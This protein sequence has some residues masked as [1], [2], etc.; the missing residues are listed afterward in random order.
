M[1]KEE[2][3]RRDLIRKKEWGKNN[4]EEIK[5][6]RRQYYLKNTEYCKSKSKEWREKN[7][8]YIIIKNK[9][10]NLKNKDKVKQYNREYY[11]KNKEEIIKSRSIYSI[12]RIK[13]NPLVKL[14]NILRSR[15]R[16]TLILNKYKKSK[17]SEELLGNKIEEVKKHIELQFREGM[18]WKNHGKYG[19]HIDHIIPLSSAKNEDEIIKLF[20]Y[21]N[22]QPLWAKDNLSK[23]SKIIN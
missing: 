18:T 7:K 13:T 9:E 17:R 6:R 14:K 3:N 20:H 21:T 23:G 1:T 2:R 16:T 12:I 8:E 19:W 5:R 11:E 4:P 22:L 10:Y 15:I